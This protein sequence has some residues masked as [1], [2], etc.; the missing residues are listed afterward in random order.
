LGLSRDK[1]LENEVLEACYD[2]EGSKKKA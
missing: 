2:E 1:V